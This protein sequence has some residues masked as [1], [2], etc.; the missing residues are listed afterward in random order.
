[1]TVMVSSIGSVDF[2]NEREGIFLVIRVFRE[3]VAD[4]D[5]LMR[6]GKG[7]MTD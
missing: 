1:M 6:V 4:R 2:I 7:G 3:F 5:M